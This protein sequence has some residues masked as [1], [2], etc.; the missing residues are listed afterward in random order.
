MIQVHALETIHQ[1]CRSDAILWCF[2]DLESKMQFVLHSDFHGHLLE[3]ELRDHESLK[4]IL[5][6]IVELRPR[7]KNEATMSSDSQPKAKSA[8]ES[9]R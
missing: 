2:L 1:K 5:R 6:I 8:V 3:V 7:W 9:D 4:A